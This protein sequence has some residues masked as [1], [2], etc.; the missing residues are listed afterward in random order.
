MPLKKYL[1]TIA[2]QYRL[3]CGV[4]GYKWAK[5]PKACFCGNTEEFNNIKGAR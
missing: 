4:C 5:R 3:I 1:R 2:V